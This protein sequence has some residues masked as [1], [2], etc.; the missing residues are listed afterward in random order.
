MSE[1]RY[2]EDD[3]QDGAVN[4]AVDEALLRTCEQDASFVPTL[5]LYGWRR[6]TLSIGYSQPV[7]KE[8]DLE[9]CRERQVDWVRRPTGGRAL[10]HME[11]LTYS[12]VAPVTHP[13]FCGGL[14]ATYAAIS[15][16][17]LRGLHELGIAEAHIN[18]EKLRGGT[19][20]RSPACFAALN[21]CEITVHDRKLIGSAQR[22]TQRAFLQHGS[23]LIA[24]DHD[25]FHSLLIYR[26]REAGSEPLEWLKTSTITLNDLSGSRM[27]FESVRT[28]LHR[29]MTAHFGGNWQ[30]AGLTAAEQD[31]REDILQRPPPVA[32]AGL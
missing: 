22:R 18:R 1:W 26:N 27:E 10:L 20:D 7:E 28:A 25:L 9:R 30:T 19:H 15:R 17:L 12:M 24:T 31:L 23:V 5:R 14:K 13:L 21:H 4:M 6:P 8:I 3:R 32:Q 16:A 29:G 2:I 11:E